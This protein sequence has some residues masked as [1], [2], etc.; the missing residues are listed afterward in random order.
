M[1]SSL[2]IINCMVGMHPKLDVHF[3]IL[4]RCPR[5]LLEQEL[6]VDMNISLRDLKHWHH[7][8]YQPASETLKSAGSKYSVS[9]LVNSY[10]LY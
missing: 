7:G 10:T 1:A 2:G 3:D 9:A 8:V 4:L 5:K 6:L